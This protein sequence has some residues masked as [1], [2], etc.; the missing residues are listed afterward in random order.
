MPTRLS[1]HASTHHPAG[2][3]PMLVSEAVQAAGGWTSDVHK[4][5]ELQVVVAFE[6]PNGRQDVLRAE[7]EAAGLRLHESGW[8]VPTTQEAA[9]G[10]ITVT[11]RG[12]RDSKVG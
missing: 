3:V 5:G 7:L 12:A 6:I 9:P 2:L 11:L 10:A 4:Y 1:L 8:E